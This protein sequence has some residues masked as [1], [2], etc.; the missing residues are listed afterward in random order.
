M[1]YI[2]NSN[3]ISSSKKGCEQPCS[4]QQLNNG[5]TFTAVSLREKTCCT[6]AGAFRDSLPGNTSVPARGATGISRWSQHKH[7]EKDGTWLGVGAHVLEMRVCEYQQKNAKAAWVYQSA[8]AT[9]QTGWPRAAARTVRAPGWHVQSWL[10]LANWTPH[11]SNA[12]IP[13]EEAAGEK[14]EKS[15]PRRCVI[16]LNARGLPH[17]FNPSVPLEIM[18]WNFILLVVTKAT[19]SSLTLGVGTVAEHKQ[20]PESH[21]G[22]EPNLMRA[23]EKPVCVFSMW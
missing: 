6:Q 14:G 20:W 10:Y 1:D 13:S 4:G 17:P 16:T 5:A 12:P 11:P 18:K 23:S 22:G 9:E 7:W 3:S 21:V 15:R 19:I 8:G 2:F